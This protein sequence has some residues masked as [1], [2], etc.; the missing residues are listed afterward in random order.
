MKNRCFLAILL[1]ALLLVLSCREER[2]QSF[3][4]VQLCDPQLG[5]G[6]YEHDVQT[7][8]QA[9]EQI[10][11][12][13]SD[14][15]FN[16]FRKIIS[17]FEIPCYLVAGNHDVGNIPNDSSLAYFRDNIGKDYYEFEFGGYAFVVANTQ[18]WKNHIGEESDLH[19]RWFKQA[20]SAAV[21]KNSPVFVLGHHPIFVERADEEEGYFNLP[22]GKREELL[23]LLSGSGTVAY[24]SGHKHETLLNSYK[25]IQ[26]VTGES[27]SRNFDE[28][29]LG[30]RLW[31]VNPDSIR[32][33]FVP[34]DVPMDVSPDP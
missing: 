28:R 7:L 22:S 34:L 11:G 9:V 30:F 5:M 1:F 25:G 10:N 8:G 19:D 13:D 26:L 23:D 4:F 20:L 6:G 16:D 14:S 31:N 27:T 15:S 17:E 29:P 18:L 24:L 2:P 32:H 3:S 12:M 33:R 21:E